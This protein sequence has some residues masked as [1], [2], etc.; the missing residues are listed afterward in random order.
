MSDRVCEPRTGHQWTKFHA[1]NWS[2]VTILIFKTLLSNNLIS[3]GNLSS[4]HLHSLD[5][6]S[7]PDAMDK[8]A[9][10]QSIHQVRA[11]RC[12][13]GGKENDSSC[14]LLQSLHQLKFSGRDKTIVHLN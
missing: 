13:S 12:E 11:G 6:S 10:S 1:D 7:E 3:S 4:F 5:I 8:V 14:P 9:S 2:R